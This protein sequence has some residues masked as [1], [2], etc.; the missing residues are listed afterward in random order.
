MAPAL[1]RRT[2]LKL[3]SVVLAVLVW[4]LVSGER[5]A[6]RSMRIPLEFTNLSAELEIVGDTPDVVDVRVRGSSGALSRLSSGDLVAMIDLV[7]AR[8]GQ[9]LF[10][11]TNADVRAPFGIDVMQVSPSSVPMRFD[12]SASKI[13]PIVP[14]VDGQ[15]AD[16]YVLG[17]VTAS[18]ASVEVVGPQSAVASLVEATTEPVLVTD[19]TEPIVELVTVG[20]TDPSVRLR[21]PL[22]ARVT[23]D[24]MPGVR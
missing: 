15:P 8:P 4:L 19:A 21:Q 12:R 22:T 16:G 24:V 3:L 11:I 18:P 23:V 20:V 10:H 5:L 2:G 7:A 13:V 17:A 1:F 6:E 9:R 14:A